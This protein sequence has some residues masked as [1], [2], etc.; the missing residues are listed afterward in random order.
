LHGPLLNENVPDAHVAAQNAS[1]MVVPAMNGDP[2]GHT[3]DECFEH[4]LV[5]VSDEK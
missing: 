2:A 5:F 1:L 3:G 4:G